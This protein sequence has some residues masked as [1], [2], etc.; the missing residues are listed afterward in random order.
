AVS[1]TAR[2]V[3]S[4]KEIQR[5]LGLCLFSQAGVALGLAVKIYNDFP[6]S[7]YGEAVHQQANLVLTTIT[8]TIIIVQIIGPL[9]VRWAIH[10]AGEVGGKTEQLHVAKATLHQ[11]TI[12]SIQQGSEEDAHKIEEL[13]LTEDTN[14]RKLAERPKKSWKRKWKRKK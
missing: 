1:L 2:A 13:K 11:E 6:A 8:G 3:K 7:V 9:L 12:S 14:K 5:Y 10:K 4:P